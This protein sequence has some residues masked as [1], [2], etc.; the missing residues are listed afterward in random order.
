MK[1]QFWQSLVIGLIGAIIAQSIGIV[2]KF[3]LDALTSSLGP[4]KVAQLFPVISWIF[5]PL[6]LVFFIF[7]VIVA[8]QIGSTTYPTQDVR[9]PVGHRFKRWHR[10]VGLPSFWSQFRLTVASGIVIMALILY[11][12]IRTSFDVEHFILLLIVSTDIFLEFYVAAGDIRNSLN[13]SISQLIASLGGQIDLTLQEVHG[14]IAIRLRIRVLILDPQ[15]Q[16]FITRYQYG[17]DGEPDKDLPLG[18]HQ[19]VA[20]R[21]FQEGRPWMQKPYRPETLGFSED[22]IRL[23]P[24]NI[25]WK[26]GLPLLCDHRPFGVLAIDCDKELDQ[27]ILDRILD[28]THG[29]TTGVAILL[30]QFPGRE[31]QLAIPK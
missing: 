25:R 2:F 11:N 26:M 6:L 22:Q 19:G 27:P 4:T 9:E 21:V 30:S 31:I 8:L 15:D 7:L 13:R 20:G 10:I 17:M 18:I 3:L 28:L 1:K 24:Q 14:D 29:I 16:T 12:G 23:I 5:L